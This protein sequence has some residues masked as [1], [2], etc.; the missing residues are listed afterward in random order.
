MPALEQIRILAVDDHPL[1]SEGLATVIRN[2]PDMLLVGE[3]M[4]RA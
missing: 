1:L 4:Q 3:G 2:Q